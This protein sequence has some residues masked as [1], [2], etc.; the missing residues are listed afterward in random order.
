VPLESL[1]SLATDLSTRGL[2]TVA[3]GLSRGMVLPGEELPDD[4]LSL[5]DLDAPE[6]DV[7]VMSTQ[8]H[9]PG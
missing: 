6:S 7:R 4:L 1:S 9:K 3:P 8:L 2:R 5:E